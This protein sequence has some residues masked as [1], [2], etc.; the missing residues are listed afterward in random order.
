MR[1]V[2]TAEVLRYVYGAPAVIS[3]GIFCAPGGL[4]EK[5]T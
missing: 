1:P 4:V 3:R 5:Q 2:F